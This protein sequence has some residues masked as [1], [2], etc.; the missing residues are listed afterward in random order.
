MTLQKQMPKRKC[1]VKHAKH[2]G[3]IS[4]PIGDM[5]GDIS[6][7]APYVTTVITTSRLV[8]PWMVVVP[9]AYQIDH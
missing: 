5:A 8:M 1:L 4:S 9:H 2:I 6:Q 7:S 3:L